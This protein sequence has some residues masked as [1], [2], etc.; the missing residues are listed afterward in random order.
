MIGDRRNRNI[1]PR[2][3]DSTVMATSDL[4]KR[5]A[6]VDTQVSIV[7]ASTEVEGDDKVLAGPWLV[8]GSSYH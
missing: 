6:G 8:D 5:G 7:K 2:W 1:A 4:A 3:R